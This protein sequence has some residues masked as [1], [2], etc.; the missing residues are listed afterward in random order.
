V[1]GE[2]FDILHQDEARD[3]HQLGEGDWIDAL[4]FVF[5][6]L[7]ARVLKLKIKRNFE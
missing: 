5:L 7:Y 2:P 4:L 6:E 3:E 1:E